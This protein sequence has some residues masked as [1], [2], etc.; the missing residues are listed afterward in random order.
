MIEKLKVGDFGDEVARLHEALRSLG[1]E[2]SVQ[3]TRRKFFGPDT[4]KAIQ[5]YQKSRGLDATGELDQKTIS[6]FGSTK[7]EKTTDTVPAAPFKTGAPSSLAGSTVQ[8]KLTRGG[9]AAPAE[10]RAFRIQGVLTDTNGDRAKG[11]TVRAFRRDTTGEYPLGLSITDE[12][13]RYQILYSEADSRLGGASSAA[14][15]IIRVFQDTELLHE[16]PVPRS[17]D[18]D[19]SID[20]T[21]EVPDRA[22][23]PRLS[24]QTKLRLKNL[25]QAITDEKRKAKLEQ[26]FVKVEGDFQQ[27]QIHLSED[28]DFDKETIQQVTFTRDL[29]ELLEDEEGLVAAFIKDTRTKSL[30][31]IAFNFRKNDLKAL[32]RTKG[33]P[34]DEGVEDEEERLERFATR[35]NDRLFQMAPAAVIQRMVRDED[36]AR[37]DQNVRRGLLAFFNGQ[38]EIDFR[39]TSVLQVLQVPDSLKDVPEAHREQVVSHLKKLQRLSSVSPRA[40]ALPVLMKA[41]LTSAYAINEVPMERFVSLFAERL[42]GVEVARRVHRNA[43]NISVRNEH[44]YIALRQAVLDPPIRMIHGGLSTDDRKALLATFVEQKNIPVNYETLFG[45]VD[46]CE[47]EH[48]NS[49]Y[50]PAAY[51]VELFQYLR[52]NNLDPE[53]PK[54]GAAGIQE[55]PLEKIQETPL[56]KFFRRRPDLGLLQLTCEN[57]NTLIPYIDLVNEV[58]ESFV[59]HL[60]AYEEDTHTPKQT[61]IFTHNVDDESS[62]ELLAEPQHT[63]CSAY[64]IL[65]AAVYPVCRL[66]YHQPIDAI[67]R[68]LDYLGTSRYEL[69]DT[70][71]ANASFPVLNAAGVAADDRAKRMEELKV[72]RVDRAIAAEYLYLTQEEYVILTKEAFY[73]REWYELR[74]EKNVTEAQYREII[75]LK[76][77]WAYYGINTETQMLDELKWVK[78]EQKTGLLGFLRRANILYTDLIDL[79]KTQYINPNYPSGK[80]LAYMN[81]LRYSYRYLQSL[82]DNSQADIKLKYKNLVRFLQNTLSVNLT[83]RFERDY[84]EC[85]VYK[86]FAKIGKLIVLENASSCHCIEG[87]IRL[88]VI[89]IGDDAGSYVDFYLDLAC[90]IHVLN[91][92][93][94][95]FVGYLDTGTGK[96]MFDPDFSSS[97]SIFG[98]SFT[99]L[100]GEIGA[101]ADLRLFILESENRMPF[102]CTGYE[103]TCDISRTQLKHLD[104]TDL[105]VAEYDC[106]HRFIRLWC[107]LGWSIAE[108]DQAIA[109]VGDSK[110]DSPFVPRNFLAARL[111]PALQPSVDPKEEEGRA[112]KP[113]R[114]TFTARLPGSKPEVDCQPE[115]VSQVKQEITPY[116]IEQLVAVK[117]LLEI[118]GL[119]LP[120]LLTYWT[121]IGTFGENSLYERLFLKYNLVA[122]DK[123]FEDPFG[124]YLTQKETFGDHLPILMAALKIDVDMIRDIMSTAGIPDELTL[125]NVSQLYRHIL[126]AKTLGLRVKEL[127]GVLAL[128][129]LLSHPFGQPSLTLKFYELFARIEE[130]GF[131][132]RELSYLLFDHDDPLRPLRP[133]L[134]RTF[135]LAIGLRNALMQIDSDHPDIKEDLEA[136]EEWLRTKLSLLYDGTTVEQIIT[137]LQGTTSYLDNTRSQY[138]AKLDKADQQ[139]I[140]D[141]LLARQKEEEKQPVGE[142]QTF[143][144]RV[145]FNGKKGLQITGILSQSDRDKVV[146]QLAGA[147]QNDEARD[148]FLIAVNKMFTQPG[149]FF[150]DVLLPIFLNDPDAAREALLAEDRINTENQ[151]ESSDYQK[152]VF[153]AKAFVPYLREEL[154]RRQV[155]QMLAAAL[156]LDQ[157]LAEALVMDVVK[158]QNGGSIYEEIIR[159]K[160][161][162]DPEASPQRWQGFFVPEKDGKYIF[163]L[164]AEGQAMLSFGNRSAWSGPERT[165]EE[166]INYYRSN[167]LSLKADQAYPFLL[168]GHDEDDDGNIIGLFFKFDDQRQIQVS[169]KNLFPALRTEIFREAY[170]RLHKAAMLVKGFDMT[171]EEIQFF[172]NPEFSDNFEGFDFNS[173]TFSQWLRLE[174]FY[175]LH[176][177]ILRKDFGLIEFLRWSNRE[178]EA[179]GDPSLASQISVLTGWEE[180]DVAAL[181]AFQHFNLSHRRHFQD[182]K[183]L[184]KL[185]HALNVAKKIGVGISLLFQW[186]KPTSTFRNTLTIAGS[187]RETIRA[188]YTQE[189]WEE[190]IKPVHDQLRENQKQALI[191]YLLAQ[192]V[193]SEWGVRNADSLFEFFLIDVQMDACMETSRI[194]QAI[195]SVQLFVQRCFLGLEDKYGV[196]S[197]DLNRDRWEWMSRYRVWEANRKIFLYPENWIRPELRDVKSPFFEELQS[198]LLQN[199]ISDEAVIDALKKYIIQVDEVANL[200][201]VGHYLEGAAA[202][203]PNSDGFHLIGMVPNRKIHVFARTRNAPYFFY[204]RYYDYESKYWYPWEK[205]EVDIPSIDVENEEGE[206]IK[207]GAFLIPV[208]WNYRLFIFFPQFLRKNWTSS[209]AK[210][211]SASDSGTK[212]KMGDNEPIP[213]WEIKMGWSEYKDRKWTPKNISTQSIN[214]LEILGEVEGLWSSRDSEIDTDKFVFASFSDKDWIKVQIFYTGKRLSVIEWI[215]RWDELVIYHIFKIPQT[216]VAHSYP[217]AFHFNGDSISTSHPAFN[218]IPEELK[219]ERPSFH[220]YTKGGGN[221]I[222]PLQAKGADSNPADLTLPAFTKTSDSSSVTVSSGVTYRFSFPLAQKLLEVLAKNELERVFDSIPLSDDN[223]G[224]NGVQ[225]HELRRPYAIYNWETLF[226]SAALTA[227]HLSKSQRFEESMKWWHFIFDPVS[228]Q[229]NI[230]NVWKFL[231]FREADSENIL[232]KIFNGLGPNAPDENISDWRDNPFQPHVIALSRP[233]A[234]MKWVVM[235]YIDNLIAWG[236]YLFRQ[237]TIETLNQA[238]QLYVLAGHILG[239]RPEFIPKR[240]KIQPKSYM[241]LVNEW[242]AFSN[243]MV[244]LELLFPFSSQIGAREVSDGKPHYVNVYGFATSL[245]FCIPANPK[246]LEYWNTVADRLFKIRHCLNIEGVFRKLNL[247]EPPIDPA[248]LV[249]AA[250]QGLSISSVLNDL[251]TP[252]PNYRFNY[253]L[254]RALEV[255]SEVR[256]LGNALLSALEKKDGESLSILRAQHDTHIQNLLMEVRKKQLEETEKTLEGLEQNR[257]APEYRLQYYL[258]QIGEE[259]SVPPIDAEFTNLENNMPEVKDDGDLKLIPPEAEEIK[260]AKE[261]ADSQLAVGILETLAGILNLIPNFAADVKPFGIGAGMEFGGQYLGSAVQAVARGVQIRVNYTSFQSSAAARKAG[262]TRQLQERIFQANLAGHELMQIDKQMTAQ[263]IRAEIAQLEIDNHEV[264]I[265]QTREMEEFIRSKYSNEQLYRWMSD[266]LKGLYYQTYSFAYDLAKKAEKVFRFEMGLSTSDY[267][268]FGYWDSA[269]DGF[270]AGEQ[271]YLALK[272]LENAYVEAK[273]HDYEIVK[274]I[275]LK[276]LDPLALI[277]LKEVGACEFDLREEFFDLDYPGHYKRRIKTVSVSIPCIV[278]P[279]TNLN[280]TVRLMKHEYRNSKVATASDYAKKLEEADE[281]FVY[282][283]IPTTAIAVSQG[284]ND[285]GVFE[286]NFRDE[287]YLPFEGAGAISSWRLE[288]PQEFRQFD[289]QTIT[290]VILHFRY[291]SSEGG[292]TLRKAA[293]DHLKEY[294]Q[295]AADL[296]QREGLFQMLSLKHE[297]PSEWHR[298]LFP[299]PDAENQRLILGRLKDRL[300]FFAKHEMVGVLQAE[301]FRL[302]TPAESLALNLLRWSEAE[303]MNTEPESI[304]ELEPEPGASISTLHQYVATDVAEDLNGFWALQVDQPFPLTSDLLKDAWLVIKYKLKILDL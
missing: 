13:G 258:Q 144:Q 202:G 110:A 303:N 255:T 277:E 70:F 49:V 166:Q 253:L 94:K 10:T 56:E 126:L 189:E 290:D 287:R 9:G 194:K 179:Q 115:P 230:K 99:G 302:F 153:F 100:N 14:D 196:S 264:Q 201:V 51:L 101:V 213:Y 261:S 293:V 118:T 145:Q 242:D 191:A 248:L 46:L 76:P 92:D 130:S 241:A 271:L 62:G 227:D 278:G 185:Q 69:F 105:V 142:F 48:C 104:G 184:L 183:N 120:K 193:L 251:S 65:A 259:E 113:F 256:S 123:V 208:V 246:L 234:Y 292:E 63:N 225:Y 228:V 291:T 295:N 169:D 129:A 44:A 176:K 87:I 19:V 272:Q 170:L 66:P 235:K 158:T 174:A 98:G 222:F 95:K 160:E 47:C 181:I 132:H 143:L 257:K 138:T 41:G 240:G 15:I 121:S 84:V 203:V 150:D 161:Q 33:V 187:V 38:P 219:E 152:R 124:T 296:S 136:T 133:P 154:R 220:Y 68:Y 269:K 30:R 108:V 223:Y 3:E 232:A 207:N 28:P 31:D 239:P 139:A 218:H 167:A 114:D 197:E 122:I 75:G 243:T 57:T 249:Q 36:L 1:F 252:M 211:Q 260:K 151:A 250:A 229:G 226:H 21:V 275:S 91:S 26:L 299:Q 281:R 7:P 81:S 32:I 119:E 135:Q 254:Q 29:G 60:D 156:G 141:F 163:L 146:E 245:Y 55:T 137:L 233:T 168:E 279:Y 53:N 127:P 265:E 88:E 200:E 79:L 11:L 164:E 149:N 274:Q 89:H 266:Q 52:N 263:K 80:A 298:F 273:P 270:L 209:L 288:L 54:T 17:T 109:G 90:Q 206:I 8:P 93:P 267:I 72:Q 300:P 103:E 159:L 285:S 297:F 148:K 162:K 61:R 22:A 217:K 224:A 77:T 134:G 283:P 106:M 262:F 190:A 175:R 85:W 205:V 111:L 212:G 204:Y 2:V 172:Q 178:V 42:G 289:Y 140:T 50:S 247:F 20:L 177:S 73:T 34:L 238:T 216:K 195:S 25:T 173:V 97:N 236:D 280:C 155:V 237:D 244:D 282:N 39:K 37:E 27:V 215:E 58:M 165:D 117:K 74:T 6:T 276:R 24:A 71:R 198:E 16:A 125:E 214:S 284:Q 131:N 268:K 147:I 45:S 96:L 171:L 112:P 86:Y 231:P 59:I 35:V 107:K 221:K 67:R 182:E 116:L 210:G 188:R 128:M 23:P 43:Q 286:L 40:E 64:E 78:P 199:D 192:P 5:D 301:S 102:V 82:V 18:H 12:R 157:V 294:V 83:D 304:I 180:A 186:G 4:R